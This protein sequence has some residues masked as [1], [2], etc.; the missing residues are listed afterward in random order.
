MLHDG[1]PVEPRPSA[2]VIVLRGRA[3][4]ETLMM[5]RPGGSEFAP[6]AYVF[7]G[8]SVQAEDALY[9][10]E[11]RAAAVRELFEELGL[12]MARRPGS[13]FARAGECRRLRELL[14][15]GSPWKDAL[16]RLRLTP[17]FD[18]LAFLT[19]WI[20]P[21]PLRRRF[22]ARF[23]V[24]RLPAGQ[25]EHPQA[26]EVVDWRWVRPRDAL[27]QPGG[28]ELVFATRR[29]LESIAVE[30]DAARLVAKLRRRKVGPAILPR[31]IPTE[32][33]FEVIAEP[34]T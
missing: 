1:P 29:I 21:K 7:P 3:P 22:D 16:A 17:A 28:L 11:S 26:G 30:P 24:C 14:A 34:L 5:R 20:T 8:G 33:G 18:R 32:S 4:F 10:D 27:R 23:Y 31:I 19:R 13:R 2:S 12:L 15:G 6:N 9:D 25:V